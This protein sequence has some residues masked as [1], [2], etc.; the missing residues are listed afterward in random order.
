VK[1][2]NAKMLIAALLP[3]LAGCRIGPNYHRP[4]LPIP[5]SYHNA[6]PTVDAASASS[7]ADLPW[8]R[9]F[10]DPTLQELI[11][12]ALKNNYDLRTATERIEQARAQLGIARSSQLPQVDVAGDF[13]GG[14]SSAQTRG[15]VI[16]GLAD[17]SYQLDLFGGQSRAAE[18][19]RAQLMAT[20][21]AR[22]V[23]VL[24]LV[25]DIASNYYLLLGYDLQL[26][27][28]RD[29]AKA[30][31]R[32]VQLTQLR[33]ERGI[34]TKA[35]VLQAQQVLD[36]ANAR[37]PDLERQIGQ[38]EDA[39]S[40]LLGGYPETIR[41]G[42]NLSE[43]RVPPEVPAGLTSDL[44]QRRPDIHQA[45]QELIAANA[46]IGVARAAFFPQISL[47]GAAGGAAGSQNTSRVGIRANSSLWTYGAGLTLPV[48]SGGRLMA[49]LNSAKAGERAALIAYQQTIQKAFGG[50][51][52]ALIANQKIH[53]QRLRQEQ[54]VQTLREAVRISTLRYRGGI[55]TYLEV[56]DNQRSLYAAQITLAEIQT[57]E[58]QSVVLLYKELGGG[59][60]Q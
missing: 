51:A 16:T 29:T 14:R 10:D 43:Q 4:D 48:F 5:P 19:A 22:Q 17:A 60:K 2:D 6:P 15:N 47:T 27:I 42:L 38:T 44:L 25:S 49:E 40:L 26:K 12:T 59:W 23:V 36:T 35:E 34:A 13:S 58:F 9:V 57:S 45:E 20:E 41:R 1:P 56:L 39:I 46:E 21:D 31:Q 33:L 7:F 18:A 28:S 30:Q 52:D 37:I 53:E 3:M 54:S 24:T 50:V 8:W 32:S 55:T 11:H